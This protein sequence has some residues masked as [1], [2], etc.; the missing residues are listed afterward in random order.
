MN[1]FEDF[2]QCNAVSKTLQFSLIP[3]GKTQEN[4]EKLGI[5]KDDESRA[6]AYRAVKE[7]L[8]VYHKQH[9]AT[10]LSCFEA[11]WNELFNAYR[12]CKADATQKD[13][14]KKLAAAFCKSIS[15]HL[16]LKQKN[17]NVDSDVKK[18]DALSPNTIIKKL[19][20]Q[21]DTPDRQQLEL[22]NKFS[23]Y[24]EAYRIARDNL[25]KSNTA[26]SVAYRLIN[27]NFV[28]FAENILL[29]EKLEK[30]DKT[31]IDQANE[32]MRKNN[33][34][35]KDL[36]QYFVADNFS[37]VLTQSGIDE[38]NQML[39]GIAQENGKLKG[40]NEHCNLYTQSSGGGKIRF[41]M[42]YKQLLEERQTTSFVPEAFADDAQLIS[43][44]TDYCECLIEDNLHGIAELCDPCVCPDKVFVGKQKLPLLSKILFEDYHEII[45]RMRNELKSTCKTE[46]KMEKFLGKKFFTIEEL[47]TYIK[48]NDVVPIVVDEIRKLF[49]D[50]KSAY[51]QADLC[52]LDKITDYGKIKELLDIINEMLNVTKIFLVDDEKDKDE[53]FYETLDLENNVLSYGEVKA[54][55]L[56]D[57]RMKMLAEKENEL[58]SVRVLSLR[59]SEIKLEMKRENETLKEQIA[60]LEDKIKL[61]KQNAEYVTTLEIAPEQLKAAS[62]KI[63][64]NLSCVP[65]NT[66]LFTVYEF[67]FLTPLTQSG[68]QPFIKAVRNKVE[69]FMETSDSVSG[70]AT[71]LKNFFSKIQSFT[72]AMQEELDNITNRVAANTA[73]ITAKEQYSERLKLLQKERDEILAQIKGDD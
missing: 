37:C 5:L 58:R 67:D 34:I 40:F 7:K 61:S 46:S 13:R 73:A 63:P 45:D 39:G 52:A 66:E 54:L 55:A 21:G 32:D 11:N 48:R 10:R 15:E 6:E 41:K 24:F 57:P 2:T 3:I 68:K 69:Y 50:F 42:L 60:E 29:F 20:A 33:I 59:E 12:V 9:I 51:S 27:E 8:D 47:S 70:N 30:L 44:I 31:L 22:F 23:T 35:T 4:I 19:I 65:P 25:Y 1:I 18:D 62:A 14:Y 49:S 56:S 38:Y 16:S 36:V 71:R 72:Q 28:R 64:Q 17:N 43:A 26:S 53:W